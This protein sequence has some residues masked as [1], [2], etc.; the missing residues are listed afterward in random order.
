MWYR[1]VREAFLGLFEW[2]GV[3]ALLIQ[4]DRLGNAMSGGS[5]ITTISGR[6]GFYSIARENP[7]WSILAGIINFSFKPIDGPDHCGKAW[8]LERENTH[9]RGNDVGLFLLSIFVV[10]ACIPIS[11]FTYGSKL[12]VGLVGLVRDLKS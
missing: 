11:M 3:L 2:K 4:I 5:P 10:L 12:W 8:E 6:T 7:Y 1:N 9:K